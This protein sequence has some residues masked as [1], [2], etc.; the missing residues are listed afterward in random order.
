M[1]LISDESDE[2]DEFPD[3]DGINEI[4]VEHHIPVVNL[5]GL[6]LGEITS[7][8]TSDNCSLQ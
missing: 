6:P 1:V 8:H 7:T 4:N 5:R 3:E 2:S